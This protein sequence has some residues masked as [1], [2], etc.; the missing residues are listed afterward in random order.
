MGKKQLEKD[1]GEHTVR[2]T[3][4]TTELPVGAF[5]G[6]GNSYDTALASDHRLLVKEPAWEHW[7]QGFPAE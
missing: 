6:G 5:S 1:N 3:A 4:G 2:E 7:P